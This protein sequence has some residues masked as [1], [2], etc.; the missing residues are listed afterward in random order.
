MKSKDGVTMRQIAN[1][2]RGLKKKDRQQIVEDLVELGDIVVDSRTDSGKL[3]YRG[4][5]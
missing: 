5:E 4:G 3:I 2:F 1:N